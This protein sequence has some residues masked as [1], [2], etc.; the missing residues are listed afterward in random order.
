MTKPRLSRELFQLGLT[1]RDFE[2]ALEQ[3]FQSGRDVTAFRQLLK[4]DVAAFASALGI[5]EDLLLTLEQS[6]EPPS[7]KLVRRLMKAASDPATF[8]QM[9]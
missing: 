9:E 8:R 6:P 4:L 3:G 5:P 7:P 1:P 2:R